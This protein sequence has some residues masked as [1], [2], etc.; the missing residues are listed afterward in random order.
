LDE[1]RWVQVD[2]IPHIREDS[3][4]LSEVFAFFSDVTEKHREELLLPYMPQVTEITSLRARA[5]ERMSHLSDR[6]R[7]VLCK[8]ADGDSNK[9]IAFALG[10]SPR[11]VEVHRSHMMVKLEVRHFADAIRIAINA[12]AGTL[13]PDGEPEQPGLT[14]AGDMALDSRD[15]DSS[16]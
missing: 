7:Q 16:F 10:I 15:L 2:A 9:I 1:R 3:S 6:E 11:T 8:L 4:R 14:L 5:M 13:S 12:E